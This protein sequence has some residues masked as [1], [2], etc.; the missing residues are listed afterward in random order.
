MDW[1]YGWGFIP[2]MWFGGAMM[3]LFWIAVI[4]AIVFI[5]K[6]LMKTS[7]DRRTTDDKPLDI[8]KKRYARGEITRDEFERFKED[9]K[10]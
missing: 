3:A 1:G 9:L 7:G 5:V 2:H 10:E 4:I 8:A 6:S